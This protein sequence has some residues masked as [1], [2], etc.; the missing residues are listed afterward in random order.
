MDVPQPDVPE[1]DDVTQ[2]WW[3]ATR[4]HRLLL[5]RCAGCD[6][7][8]HPPRALC[9]CCGSTTTLGWIETA[10]DGVVDSCTVVHRAP[11]AA[12]TAPYLVA[13]VRLAEGPV[14]LTN[15]V[16]V[17]PDRVRIGDRVRLSWRDLTDGRAL[18]VFT[19]TTEE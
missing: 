4:D 9:T 7:V 3:D 12:F 2:P 1:P 6:G 15:V 17:P 13:R 11:A 10:G 18:P 19:P 5:Q 8:Q 16:C 14:L